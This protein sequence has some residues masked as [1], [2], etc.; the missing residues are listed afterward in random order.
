VRRRH[1]LGDLDA[2]VCLFEECES[3]EELYRQSSQWLKHM[4]AHALRWPCNSKSHGR[5]LGT[6]REEYIEHMKTVHQSKLTETQLRLL[7][8]KGAR[9]VGQMFKSCPL[10]GLETHGNMEEHVVGHLRGLALKSLPVYDAEDGGIGNDTSTESGS[11]PRSRST[12]KKFMDNDSLVDDMDREDGMGW[13]DDY[14]PGTSS[15]PWPAPDLSETN[16]F[17]I[18]FP[19][20]P[21]QRTTH[22]SQPRRAPIMR[23]DPCCAICSL[24]VERNCT[25]EAEEVEKLTDLAEIKM[26]G[27]IVEDMRTWVR[28]H[29]HLV[30]KKGFQAKAA[31]YSGE[32][33]GDKS[34]LADAIRK[35]R[36]IDELW[37]ETYQTYPEALEYFYNLVE[38]T[39]PDDA[40]PAVKD[41]PLSRLA[42]RAGRRAA[43]SS[44]AT[45]DRTATETAGEDA[46]SEESDHLAHSTPSAGVSRLD[47][48][49]EA[50]RKAGGII[51]SRRTRSPKGEPD[52]IFEVDGLVTT[53]R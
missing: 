7:A 40:E 24:P 37:R 31:A 9:T 48:K 32:V 18:G 27:R 28:N 1:V 33:L 22:D 13:I 25:C 14:E 4:G 8:D 52:Q 49:Q 46:A 43:T 11:E 35:K 21:T 23:M 26:M 36:R 2:Y 15:S 41:P 17:G 19:E 47:G 29:A 39:L 6:S 45:Q 34:Q 42:P 3:P 44:H 12:V 20:Q 10:C 51:K 30:I 5:F 53:L 16:S 38:L 50:E